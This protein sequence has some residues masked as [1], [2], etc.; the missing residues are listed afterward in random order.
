MDIDI[1]RLLKLFKKNLIPIVAVALVCAIV[2][3]VFTL[4]FIKPKYTSSARFK[5]N[6]KVEEVKDTVTYM[7]RLLSLVNEVT[8]IF[9]S[10]GFYE[11]VSN[12]TGGR[13]TPS[14]IPKML[15]VRIE[16]DDTTYFTITATAGSAS[17]AKQ[18]IDV[19][20][21]TAPA[22]VAQVSGD[23]LTEVVVMKRGL[24]PRSP[25]SPNVPRNTF[26]GLVVGLIL[27]LAV[28]I[29]R[30]LLDRRVKSTADLAERFGFPILGVVPRFDVNS[31]R[32]SDGKEGSK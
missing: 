11:A 24:L 17:E 23:N 15:S 5:I 9:D 19:V 25:S 7:V 20:A 13:L 22:Y 21:D 10:D 1:E 30:D 4:C 29:V 18:I 14:Q 6:L 26:L 31:P 8:G 28:V 2:A 16:S 12:G 3:C 32:D 27:S